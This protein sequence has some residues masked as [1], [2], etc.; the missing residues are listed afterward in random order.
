MPEKNTPHKKD[1][2]Y[3]STVQSDEEFAT[4]LRAVF[5]KAVEKGLSVKSA[6]DHLD[7]DNNGQISTPEMHSALLKLPHFREVREEEVE[8][9]V[10][11]LDSD[12]NGFISLEEF[13]CFVHGNADF[14]SSNQNTK[15]SILSLFLTFS[16]CFSSCLSFFLSFCLSLS[17]FIFS[18]FILSK[19]KQN[20]TFQDSLEVYLTNIE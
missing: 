17:L 4:R 14:I 11:I 2:I 10:K 19:S 12:S 7:R 6:F 5:A 3:R 20:T 8:R 18:S 1:G 9:L 13:I 15:V 16:Y